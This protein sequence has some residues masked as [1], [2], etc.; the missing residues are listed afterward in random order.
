MVQTEFESELVE[1][2]GL[3][4]WIRVTSNQILIHNG[5]GIRQAPVSRRM[6]RLNDGLAGGEWGQRYVS[7]FPPVL[8]CQ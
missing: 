6:N 3:L 5:D 4:Q 2:E 1:I 8:D 7:W